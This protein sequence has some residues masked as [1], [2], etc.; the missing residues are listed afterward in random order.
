MPPGVLE[1]FRPRGPEKIKAAFFEK[2][3]RGHSTPLEYLLPVLHRPGLLLK[4]AFPD[5]RFME[6]RYCVASSAA[7]FLRPLRLLLSFFGRR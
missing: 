3:A 1:Q 2:A 4:Y 7:Y 6:R 5:R